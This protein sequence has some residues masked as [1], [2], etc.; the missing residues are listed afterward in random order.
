MAWS[1]GSLGGSGGGPSGSAT[2]DQGGQRGIERESG[3]LSATE[4]RSQN[5]SRQRTSGVN[6]VMWFV[7]VRMTGSSARCSG[8]GAI[9][10][11]KV[12]CLGCG[13]AAGAEKWVHRGPTRSWLGPIPSQREDFQV[14]CHS[15]PKSQRPGNGSNRAMIQ[16]PSRARH[17]SRCCKNC[18]SLLFS[19]CFTALN[20]TW[21]GHA[22]FLLTLIQPRPKA[23]LKCWPSPLRSSPSSLR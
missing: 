2:G 5:D 1:V 13:T 10:G 16:S 7:D 18:N 21:I 6:Q 9:T 23:A 20:L 14:A 22:V 19:E 12:P 4:I 15:T 8:L 17:D 3:V 11:D